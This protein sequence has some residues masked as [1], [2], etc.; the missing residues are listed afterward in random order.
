MNDVK[1]IRTLNYNNVVCS[2][3]DHEYFLS[4]SPYEQDDLLGM[5]AQESMFLFASTGDYYM[6][7]D[8]MLEL[9]L[10]RS[11]GKK[12]PP[13]VI[14]NEYFWWLCNI[15]CLNGIIEDITPGNAT[16]P[17][18]DYETFF[19]LAYI[20][21]TTPFI[22]GLDKDETRVYEGK[23]LR[24]W[25]ATLHSRYD[26]YECLNGPCSMLEMLIALAIQIDV[27]IMQGPYE[28]DRSVEWFWEMLRNLGISEFD[29]YHFSSEN[30]RIIRDALD[31][32]NTRRYCKDGSGGLYPLKNANSDQRFVPIWVQMQ[33][34]FKENHLKYD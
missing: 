27:Q 3:E 13:G 1:V 34:Y 22:C 16:I 19:Q 21:F 29:D 24:Y 5:N 32:I 14:K 7:D 31:R 30:A 28:K 4:L 17:D 25:W 8:D 9:G 12:E 20:L 11:N 10:I 2:K 23:K 18:P 6:N 33:E 26:N 15:S